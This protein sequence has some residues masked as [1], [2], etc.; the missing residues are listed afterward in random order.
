M[1]HKDVMF[2]MQSVWGHFL[3]PMVTA[4]GVSLEASILWSME[5][6]PIFPEFLA[7]LLLAANLP[8]HPGPVHLALSFSPYRSLFTQGHLD[9]QHFIPNSCV[10]GE[11]HGLCSLLSGHDS[12]LPLTMEGMVPALFW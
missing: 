4:F 12:P 8:F 2:R 9:P 1:W 10:T 5:H 6:V 3:G 7:L 11:G